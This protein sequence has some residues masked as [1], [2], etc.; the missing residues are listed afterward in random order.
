VDGA[1]GATGK[2]VVLKVALHD[3]NDKDLKNGH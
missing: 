3:I 2:E 1:G